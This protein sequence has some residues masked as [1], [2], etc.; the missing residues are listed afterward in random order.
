MDNYEILKLLDRCPKLK[1]KFVGVYAADTFPPLPPNTF[2]IVNASK[3]DHV[4]THWILLCRKTSKHLIFA[5]PLGLPVDLYVD[6]YVRAARFY[7]VI[8]EYMIQQSIQPI[9]SVK[10]GL[11]CIYLAHAIFSNQY[12]ALPMIHEKELEQF[13]IHMK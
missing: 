12:P 11:Y 9:S 3:A 2:Q 6:I 5:D 1:Y 8:S 10:C 7:P 13:I 4:G